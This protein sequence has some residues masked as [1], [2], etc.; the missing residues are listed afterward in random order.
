[1]VPKPRWVR[2]NFSWPRGSKRSVLDRYRVVAPQELMLVLVLLLLLV[3]VL[4][5]LLTVHPW[6]CIL[7][8]GLPGL[9]SG[10]Q[11]TFNTFRTEKVVISH[12]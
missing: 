1:M 4:L 11:H 6:P 8:T 7:A 3:L 5:L 9:P 2:V 10:C 12:I